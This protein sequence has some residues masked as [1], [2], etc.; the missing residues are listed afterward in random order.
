MRWFL[1]W[2]WRRKREE[3]CTGGLRLASL[4][5]LAR[6]FDYS[7]FGLL[8]ML[9][10]TQFGRWAFTGFWFP[11]KLVLLTA[12]WMALWTALARATPGKLLLRLRVRNLEPACRVGLAAA[13]RP[14][15]RCLLSGVALGAPLA[16]YTV[17]KAGLACAA[18][19]RPVWDRRAS[20]WVVLLPPADRWP[21]TLSWMAAAVRLSVLAAVFWL[22][23]LGF[24]PQPN[25]L[26]G[27]LEAAAGQVAELR[28]SLPPA[29]SALR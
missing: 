9:A 5:L 17:A 27:A 10:S 8:L 24:E 2:P 21:F 22:F 26:R 11:V 7:L 13:M 25:A 23:M 14:E 28:V 6:L 15:G 12:P 16:V 18:Q 20:T 19:V 1:R 4:R 3:S 29:V